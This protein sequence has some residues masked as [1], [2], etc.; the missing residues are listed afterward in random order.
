[1]AFFCL[2]IRKDS[3]SLKRFPCFSHVQILS[4]EISLVCRLKYPYSCFSSHF[5]FLVI[6]VLLVLVLFVLFL[7]AVIHSF[8]HD[9][10]VVAS[11]SRRFILPSFLDTYS[12]SVSSFRCKA[13]L[14]LL[15]SLSDSKFPNVPRT[16]LSILVDVNNAFDTCAICVVSGRCNLYF[17]V[18]S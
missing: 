17:F 8:L 14:L 16:L 6:V 10:F 3:V 18:L 4:C 7:V 2:A 15:V 11:M 12:L 5:C 13:L 9:I 1:M